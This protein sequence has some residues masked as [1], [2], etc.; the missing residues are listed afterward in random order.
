[1]YE[2]ID[3]S[4]N[5]GPNAAYYQLYENGVMIVDNII[6]PQFSLLMADMVQGSYEYQVRGVN[7]FGPGPL[8]DP[9]TV[10]FILPAKVTG[11]KYSVS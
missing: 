2:R 4:W 10:N 11:L 8:S 9:V 3:F 1:M 6:Q 7:E 5:A